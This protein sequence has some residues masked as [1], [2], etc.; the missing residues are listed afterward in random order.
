MRDTQALRGVS[1]ELRG[2]EDQ[3]EE[4]Q[5]E[6]LA[7][8]ERH[9]NPWN[10]TLC[11][12]LMSPS[13]PHPWLQRRSAYGASQFTAP[14]PLSARSSRGSRCRAGAICERDAACPISTG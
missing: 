14:L 10:S 9:L 1:A 13:F 6:A 5:R 3:F 4:T 12:N 7:Q 11:K 2:A 8:V